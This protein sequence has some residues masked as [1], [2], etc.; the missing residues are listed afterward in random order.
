MLRQ[1]PVRPRNFVRDPTSLS[2]PTWSGID[3]GAITADNTGGV[4]PSGGCVAARTTAR[5]VPLLAV[6][7]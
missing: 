2:S 5:I 6:R 7:S 3:R 4:V 1:H